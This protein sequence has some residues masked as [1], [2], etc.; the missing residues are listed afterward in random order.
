DRG[1]MD[2]QH[3]TVEHFAELCPES[4]EPNLVPGIAPMLRSLAGRPG[5]VLSLVTGNLEPVAR[6]KLERAGLGELF[7]RGQ[8]G[9]GSD[10]E[11]RT[12]LPAIARRRAGGEDG[13]T[14]YPR[15]R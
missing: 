10:S 11:D 14:P 5:V 7:E 4:L 12:D 9:F 1:L 15:E 8:G 13:S 3:A 2:V 6:V